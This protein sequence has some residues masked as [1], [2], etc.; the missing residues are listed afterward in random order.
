MGPSI[1]W[2]GSKIST[3]VAG[4]D[5]NSHDFFS[6]ADTATFS[7]IENFKTFSFCCSV[8]YT[9]CKFCS[10]ASFIRLTFT[11]VWQI[12]NRPMKTRGR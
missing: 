10:S 12:N 6:T 9:T 4:L 11:N 7:V 8:K 1:G 5:R 3:D 2:I